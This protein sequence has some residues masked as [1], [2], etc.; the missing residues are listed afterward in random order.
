[1]KARLIC[2]PICSIIAFALHS[3]GEKQGYARGLSGVPRI[4]AGSTGGDT[5]PTIFDVSFDERENVLFV[6][7]YVME[8]GILAKHGM[9]WTPG[10]THIRFSKE[11][12]HSL[13]KGSIPIISVKRDKEH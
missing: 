1:M 10:G 7:T 5:A 6:Q 3:L 2:I 9:K 11:T 13:T 4:E 12:N 8:G